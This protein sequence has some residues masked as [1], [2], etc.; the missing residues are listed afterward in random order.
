[1][2]GVLVILGITTV[3][4]ILLHPASLDRLAA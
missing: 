2:G 3:V 1:V 4:L